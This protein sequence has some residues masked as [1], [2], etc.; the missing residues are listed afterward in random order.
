MQLRY[1]GELWY[2]PALGCLKCSLLAFYLS[3]TPNGVFRKCCWALAIFTA[4]LTT[5]MDIMLAFACKPILFWHD[6]LNYKCISHD[7][8]KAA[9]YLQNIT[10][11]LTDFA[12]L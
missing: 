1:W 5:Q 8:A 11:I 10:N 7:A 12:I 9:Y 4:L 3:L 2:L 6:L